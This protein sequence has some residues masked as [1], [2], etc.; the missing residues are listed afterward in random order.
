M[1]FP[2]YAVTYEHM[3]MKLT[4]QLVLYT[5]FLIVA[6]KRRRGVF[7]NP[8]GAKNSLHYWAFFTAGIFIQAKLPLCTFTTGGITEW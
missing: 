7:G 3:K 4:E 8:F 6:P 2:T 5:V 1:Y